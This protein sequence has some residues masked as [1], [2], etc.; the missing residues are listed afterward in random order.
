MLLAPLSN[1]KRQ[2]LSLDALAGSK[3]LLHTVTC[4]HISIC[5]NPS[6]SF[7]DDSTISRDECQRYE[8]Y[9]PSS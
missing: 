8:D 3:H 5:L 7:L 6:D 9:T 2:R 1:I 4:K